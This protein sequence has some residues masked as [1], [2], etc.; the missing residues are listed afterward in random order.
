MWFSKLI[1]HCVLCTQQHSISINV[2]STNNVKY[3]YRKIKRSQSSPKFPLCYHHD[4]LGHH[5]SYLAKQSFYQIPPFPQGLKIEK[6]IATKNGS[7]IS[8]SFEF[9]G[10]RKGLSALHIYFNMD[11]VNAKFWFKACGTTL[12]NFF[13]KTTRYLRLLCLWQCFP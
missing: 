5:H 2:Y 8:V 9:V 4:H 3:K 12:S 11:D 7:N 10:K 1:L 13:S 6:M